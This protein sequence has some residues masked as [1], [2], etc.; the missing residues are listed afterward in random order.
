MDIIQ[1]EHL[2]IAFQDFGHALFPID[3]LSHASQMFKYRSKKV[4]K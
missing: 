1:N 3:K 2:I 4:K